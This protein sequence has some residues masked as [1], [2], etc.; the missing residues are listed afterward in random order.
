[1]TWGTRRTIGALH[2]IGLAP[3][4]RVRAEL[5]VRAE[6]GAYATRDRLRA[7]LNVPLAPPVPGRKLHAVKQ[8][9][10]ARPAAARARARWHLLEPQHSKEYML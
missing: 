2:I 1:M 10:P 8:Q 6:L 7:A 5:L 9:H 3:V 4:D